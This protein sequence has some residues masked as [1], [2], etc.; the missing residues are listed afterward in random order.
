M[1][2]GADRVRHRFARSV[3]AVG[4]VLPG[5]GHVAEKR[6]QRG[7]VRQ[8]LAHGLVLLQGISFTGQVAA[9]RPE[10]QTNARGPEIQLWLLGEEVV[11]PK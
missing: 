6:R 3:T 2:I 5:S 10:L 9:S 1:K 7:H 8:A 4:T 11:F